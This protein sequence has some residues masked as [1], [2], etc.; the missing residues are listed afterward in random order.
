MQLI[1]LTQ[2]LFISIVIDECFD[3]ELSVICN[4]IYCLW[5]LMK[6]F[7]CIASHCIYHL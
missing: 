1:V 4:V 7:T 3:V 5:M 2:N 6:L